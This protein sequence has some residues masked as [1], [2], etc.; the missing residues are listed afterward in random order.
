MKEEVHFILC[1]VS[2]DEFVDAI[3]IVQFCRAREADSI[4]AITSDIYMSDIKASRK[5][6]T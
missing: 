2:C 1:P 4:N 3:H 5:S 6:S